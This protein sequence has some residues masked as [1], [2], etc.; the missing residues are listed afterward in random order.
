MQA[1][2]AETIEEAAGQLPTLPEWFRQAQRQE[3]SSFGD[4]RAKGIGASGVTNDFWTGYEL[5]LQT[6]R[7][8]IAGSPAIL[9]A[10]V[11]PSDVL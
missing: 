6:A 4:E 11:K 1:P 3:V 2:N 10:G 7:L 5:G 8:V 9:M